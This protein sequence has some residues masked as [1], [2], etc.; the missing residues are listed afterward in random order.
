VASAQKGRVL[1]E[2]AKREAADFIAEAASRPRAP[3]AD[4]HHDNVRSEPWPER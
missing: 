3:G 2:Q 4:R 1:L